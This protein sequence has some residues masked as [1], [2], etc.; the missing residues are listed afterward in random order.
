MLLYYTTLTDERM[1]SRETVNNTLLKRT[2]LRCVDRKYRLLIL[3][4]ALL[5]V[6]LLAWLRYCHSNGAKDHPEDVW[7]IP[8]DDNGH[9]EKVMIE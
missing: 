5:F 9:G 6:S 4:V 1:N 7:G 8:I 2:P 3:L